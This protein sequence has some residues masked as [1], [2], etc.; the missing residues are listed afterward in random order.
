MILEEALFSSSSGSKDHGSVLQQLDL[1]L[2]QS[3]LPVHGVLSGRRS[4]SSW[5]NSSGGGDDFPVELVDYFKLHARCLILLGRLSRV[6]LDWAQKLLENVDFVRTIMVSS[7][8][9]S[10][11]DD[12]EEDIWKNLGDPA[13][14]TNELVVVSDDRTMLICPECVPRIK[15]LRSMQSILRQKCDCSPLEGKTLTV[16]YF[17]AAPY[18]VYGEPNI[19]GVDVEIMRILGRKFNFQIKFVPESLPGKFDALTRTWNGNVGNVLRSRSEGKNSKT[20]KKRNVDVVVVLGVERLLRRLHRHPIHELS[21]L[22]RHTLYDSRLPVGIRLLWYVASAR[23]SRPQCR[24]RLPVP[25]LDIHGHR[26][27][28][29]QSHFH[30]VP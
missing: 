19:T 14:F 9:S 5:Y 17:G 25:R 16:T 13:N 24:H 10:S 7:S 30:R 28:F 15:Y 29:Y 18:I 1:F 21:A 2:R 12:E 20:K 8:S 3:D 4:S 23:G 6:T 22:Q 27:R 26:L 11:S